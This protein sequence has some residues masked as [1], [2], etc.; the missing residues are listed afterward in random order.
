MNGLQLQRRHCCWE[1]R[2]NHEEGDKKLGNI[3]EKNTKISSPQ[4]ESDLW[5]AIEVNNELKLNVD[6]H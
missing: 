4:Y 5:K 2:I 3:G 1:G 6:E